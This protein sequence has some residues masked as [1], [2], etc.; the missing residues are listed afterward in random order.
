MVY[1]ISIYALPLELQNHEDAKLYHKAILG[2]KEDE[3]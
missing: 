2:L 1:N 3:N